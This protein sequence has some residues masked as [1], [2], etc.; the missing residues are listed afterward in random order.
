M[1]I[2]VLPHIYRT[3]IC[4][5][6]GTYVQGRS[7]ND[8][9]NKRPVSYHYGTAFYYLNGFQRATPSRNRDRCFTIRWTFEETSCHTA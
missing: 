5:Y 1:R 3:Y 6:V 7:A 2:N 8:R 9:V 4:T